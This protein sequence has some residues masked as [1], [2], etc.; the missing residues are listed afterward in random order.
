MVAGK[1]NFMIARIMQTYK[2]ASVCSNTK[3]NLNEQ[4]IYHVDNTI[5][6]RNAFWL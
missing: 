1:V 3:V 5:S 6:D 4:E 2:Q